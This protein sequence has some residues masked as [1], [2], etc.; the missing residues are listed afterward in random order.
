[1]LEI[2]E[3][4]AG[5]LEITYG[6][7]PIN[8]LTQ[9]QFIVHNTGFARLDK[10]AI[11]RP[12]TWHAPGNI[13]AAWT[14]VSDPPVELSFT[15]SDRRVEIEW[16]LFN[17]RCKALIKVLCE[18][19]SNPENDRLEGQIKDV[20][21]IAETEA[22]WVSEDEKIQRMKANLESQNRVSRMFG[23]VFATKWGMRITR[24]LSVTYMVIFLGFVPVNILLSEVGAQAFSFL[25]WNVVTGAIVILIALRVRN[26]YVNLMR[27]HDKS[28][29]DRAGAVQDAKP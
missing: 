17:Q 24:W 22:R 26:P 20:P 29:A 1:M 11:I 28:R 9:Y 25:A 8:G 2:D 5:S 3:E 12:L 15:V 6:G 10:E 7:R 19:V 18:N 21:E 27:L 4:V 16:P 13:V 23:R 14:A